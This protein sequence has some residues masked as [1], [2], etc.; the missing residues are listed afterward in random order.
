MDR[1]EPRLFESRLFRPADEMQT[2]QS[3]RQ[4]RPNGFVWQFC[5]LAGLSPGPS[6]LP[7]KCKQ[8]NLPNLR[9]KCGQMG[10]F[11]SFASWPGRR[12]ALPAC[13]RNANNPIFALNAA[14]WVRLAVLPSWPGCRLAL[15][16]CRR[17]AN[18]PI[19]APNAAKW[20]RLA[21]L[22]SWPGPRRALP[23][24]RRNANNPI[25]ALNAAKWVRLAVLP[26]EGP[27]I[28]ALAIKPLFAAIHMTLSSGAIF[29][30]KPVTTVIE[31]I[32]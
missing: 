28:L 21:V 4:M 2:I 25:F 3:S 13:R 24:C 30:A 29:H 1:L 18:N 26:L 27:G 8:S 32:P 16:A 5:L 20:V 6:G 14:K 15:P 31:N 10:S 22:P 19:F 17:S 9:A 7:T 11:G 23:A 12:R